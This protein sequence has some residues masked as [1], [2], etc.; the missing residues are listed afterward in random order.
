MFDEGSSKISAV[1]LKLLI[2]KNL[3]QLYG[4]V[5]TQSQIIDLILIPI[6]VNLKIILTN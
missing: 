4:T 6:I 2:K 5:K 1:D 3:G